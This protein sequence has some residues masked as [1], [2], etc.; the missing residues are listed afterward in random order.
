VPAHRLGLLQ[1]GE[2]VQGAEPTGTAG[3]DVIKLFEAGGVSM[4]K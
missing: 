1:V 3:L 4:R 2:G